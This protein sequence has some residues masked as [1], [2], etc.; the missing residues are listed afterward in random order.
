MTFTPGIPASGQSLGSSRTQVLNNFAVL[1]STIATNHIDVNN[2]GAGKHNL[3]ELVVQSQSPATAAAEVALYSRA[4]AG[5][6]E[7]FLQKENQLAAAADIQMSRVDTGASGVDSGYSFL[8]GGVIIQ[9]RIAA[10]TNPGTL[11]NFPI[12]FPTR[13]FGVN[14]GIVGATINSLHSVWCKTNYPS[15]VLADRTQFLCTSDSGALGCFMIA[16][17]N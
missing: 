8:P 10:A 2:L 15:S 14:L 4:I 17:G 11:T 6:A 13:C 1:R 3:A 5:I 7:L 9:W 12:V 16:I